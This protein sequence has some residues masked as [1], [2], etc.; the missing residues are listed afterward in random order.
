MGLPNDSIGALGGYNYQ[1]PYNNEYLLRAMMSYN[2]NFKGSQASE[3]SG[4][5]ATDTTNT[6][7]NTGTNNT[8]TQTNPAISQAQEGGITLGEGILG[9]A[10]IAGGVY[11]LIRGHKSGFFEKAWKSIRGKG[12]SSSS[13]VSERLSK[14][15]AVKCPDGKIRFTIPEKTTTRSGKQIQSFVDEYGIKG[16]ITP[17]RQ[18]YNAASSSLESFRVSVGS[19]NFVVFTKDG[20]ITKIADS[21]GENILKRLTDAE[22][23]TEDANMLE[24]FQ[25]IVKELGKEKDVD[26]TLLNGVR[27]IRYTNTYG[28]DVLKMT[29]KKYGA[30]PSLTEFTTLQRFN[31]NDKEMQTFKLGANETAFTESRLWSDGK[32]V[33]GLQVTKFSDKI[34]GGYIGNFEGQT[35]VSIVKPDGTI[36]PQGSAGYS[37]I[38]KDY[39]KDID[40]LLRKVFVKREYIPTGATIE[41]V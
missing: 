1:N 36:L 37:N 4:A 33:D 27:D 35:L 20:A 15:T 31:F 30:N 25:N 19:K 21:K 6:V 18:A 10:I 11:G 9:T 26:R 39:Q 14:L 41:T 24:K 23:K 29:A 12:G 5:N 32:L 2:A 3:T 13:S 40:K 34:G 28:D 17:E 8:G 22:S 7:T 16:A 38:V